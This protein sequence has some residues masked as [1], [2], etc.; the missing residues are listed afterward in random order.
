MDNPVSCL[1]QWLP[2]QRLQAKATELTHHKGSKV[3]SNHMTS[4]YSL[5]WAAGA[6]DSLNSPDRADKGVAISWL[7]Q[8][9]ATCWR[10]NQCL[11]VQGSGSVCTQNHMSKKGQSCQICTR[12]KPEWV[13]FH[14][15]PAPHNPAPH[16]SPSAG[17]GRDF[18]HGHWP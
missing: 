5:C 4:S 6:G 11:A 10:F 12:L 18:Q 3:Y 7:T 14:V 2:V 15:C 1:P 8:P 17:F 13:K 9:A 16:P